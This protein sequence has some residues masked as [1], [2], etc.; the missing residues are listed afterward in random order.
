MSFLSQ[1]SKA[2][3]RHLFGST[4]VAVW[5][6]AVAVGLSFAEDWCRYMHREKIILFAIEF[7]SIAALIGDGIIW[8]LLVY[9]GVKSAWKSALK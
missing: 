2:V 5:L 6:L 9:E 8:L 7:I 1:R 4:L 3:L